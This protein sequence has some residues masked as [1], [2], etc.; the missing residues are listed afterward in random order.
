MES[1]DVVRAKVAALPTHQERRV[2]AQR[3]NLEAVFSGR[4]ANSGAR[5]GA[6]GQGSAH[7]SVA[8]VVDLDF[9]G[10]EGEGG[11]CAVLAGGAVMWAPAPDRRGGNGKNPGGPPLVKPGET[12]PPGPPVEILVR[13]IFQLW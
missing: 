1:F 4:L 6:P 3:G 5:R 13:D 12:P 7:G 10:E 11:D 9:D 8:Q 2:A